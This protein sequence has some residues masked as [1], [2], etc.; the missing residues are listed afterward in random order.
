MKFTLICLSFLLLINS[1]FAEELSYSGRLVR[2]N[3]SPV[4]GAVNLK[5]DVAYSGAPSVFLCTKQVNGVAL[6][7][8]VF[9]VNIDIDNS[10]CTPSRPFADVL[11][12]VPA[13][14]S[15]ILQVSDVTDLTDIKIYPAQAFKSVPYS[16]QSN[17]AKTLSQMGATDGQVLKWNDLQSKWI[18]SND[19]GGSGSVTEVQ[20]GSGLTGGPITDTGTISIATDGV[21][22]SHILDGTISNVDISATAAIARSKIAAGTAN[23]VVINDPSGFLSSV[24]QLSVLMGGTGASNATDARTNLGLGS[25][26]TRNSGSN[27]GEVLLADGIPSCLAHQKIQKSALAPY[28][29][30]CVNDNDSADATKLPLAGGTMAGAIDMGGYR[31]SN[32]LDPAS[33][34]DAATRNYVQTYVASQL[35]GVDE[36]QWINNGSDIY[37]TD[38]VG[39]GAVTPTQKLDV[40]GNIFL[41]SNEINTRQLQLFGRDSAGTNPIIGYNAAASNPLLIS[42]TIN[43]N[44][45]ALMPH[46]TGKVGI[47]TASP[48]AKLEITGAQ[49]NWTTVNWRKSLKLEPTGGIEFSKGINANFG[50]GASSSGGIDKFYIFDTVESDNSTAPNYRFV[51]DSSTGNIGIGTNSPGA[52]L[53]VAGQI[54]IAGGTPGAGKVL[55]SDAAGLATWETPAAGGMSALT[56]DV[57]ASGSGSVAASIANSA[58]TSAKILDGTIATADL[59]DSSVTSAKIV[60]GTIVDADIANTTIT[61]SK[62]NLA[63]GSVPIAKLVRMTCLPGEVVTSDAALGFR[64]VTDNTTDTTKV[65]LAGGTMTGLLTLSGDPT[66]NLHAAT[67]QYVDTAFSGANNWTLDSGNVYRTTGNVGIG[68]IAPTDKLTVEG[69]GMVV[70]SVKSTN[71]GWAIFNVKSGATIGATV[72]ADAT[73]S[74]ASF[75]STTSTNEVRISA[76]AATGFIKMITGGNNVTTNERMRIAANGNVGIGTATPGAKL[77]VAGQVKI[78]GG[79]PGTG[80]VLTSDAAGLATWQTP[81]AGGMT[82]L[83][84]DVTASGSGSVTATIADGAVT[85]AKIADGSI[86]NADVSATANIDAS[87]LGTGVVSNTEFNYLDGVTSGIQTQLDSK[88]VFPASGTALQY[89]NGLG[90][91]NTLNTSVVP[92]SGNLYFTNARSIASTLTGLSTATTTAVTASDSILIAIGKLQAR[93]KWE[94]SGSSLHYND[95]SIKVG[96]GPSAGSSNAN[97]KY[98]TISPPNSD[99]ALAYGALRL[100]GAQNTAA[101]TQTIGSLQFYSN[102]NVSIS[103]VTGEAYIEGRLDGTGG[104]DGFGTRLVFGT[105]QDNTKTTYQRMVITNEGNVGIGVGAPT[106]KLEV[107]GN[108]KGTA[109]LNTSDRNLKENIETI[110]NATQKILGLRGVEFDWKESGEHE[111]GFIAQEVE[112]IEETLVVTSSA[113]G[114]KS[115]KYAN[116]TAILVEAFK[117]I[118][119][120]VEENKKLYTVMHEGLELKV[121][122]LERELA[123]LQEDNVRLRVDQEKLKEEN[124]RLREDIELIKKHLGIE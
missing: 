76:P 1:A 5:F 38:N 41:G 34:Q 58:V 108:V 94:P 7:N 2:P 21:T 19:G 29:F 72:Q 56:G 20:T 27:D 92:E 87:K 118:Y 11:N 104:V 120:E 86:I 47:G 63:D 83:T 53:D 114:I 75:G 51:I 109:F 88:F 17:I 78:T 32:L 113:T 98:V 55:T 121:N 69:T 64:C 116:I 68:V 85:T 70:S 54:K 48:Q 57:T 50:M 90:N 14:E 77:E 96:G 60:D 65:P 33:A 8:G 30:S 80:R 23:H 22:S 79:A 42:T 105:R 107:S 44:H 82:A 103:G 93:S 84:G 62:L 106:E 9:H 26:A 59:A 46:G 89:M 16:I 123:S 97:T 102:S 40:I 124:A 74:Y 31:I 36:S 39:I 13:N 61:Y 25:A 71:S 100:I 91:L 15:V 99:Q 18:P 45:I 111:I 52:R 35:S 122:R 95:G 67:K 28:V 49:N 24:A 43:N 73:G 115:V 37:F 3:G 66:D 112:S 110:G 6:T 10:D 117:D 119:Q 12:D 4:T 81:A 101:N